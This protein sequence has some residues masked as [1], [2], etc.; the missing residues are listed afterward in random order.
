MVVAVVVVI[1]VVVVALV[2]LVTRYGRS[3]LQLYLK[4]RFCSTRKVEK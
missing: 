1:D 2:V 4:K 3:V